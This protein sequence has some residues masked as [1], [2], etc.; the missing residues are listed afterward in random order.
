MAITEKGTSKDAATRRGGDLFIVDNTDGEWK[1]RDYLREWTEISHTFDIAT[2]SFEIGGLL[3]LDGHWQKLDRLRILMG[4]E[5]TKRTKKALLAGLESRKEILDT[6]IEREKEANDFLAGVPGIVEALRGKQIECRI[7]NKDRF[8]AKAYITHSKLSVVPSTALVGSSN[9]SFPGLTENVELNVQI[10]NEVEALQE[11]YER[12]WNEAEDITPEILKLI[13]RHTFAY[14]PFDV[15]AKALQEFFRGHELTATEWEKHQSKIY[16][17][18]AP[19]QRESYHG[20]LKSAESYNGAFLC[21]GV[22]LG[23]TFVGMMLIE[24]LVLHERLNVALFVPKAGREPVWETTLKQYLPHIFGKYSKLEIFNHTD[25]LRGR[26]QEDLES[27]RERADVIIIDEAHHFR[28]TGV[29]GTDETQRKSQYWRMFDLTEGKKL[30]MLTATPINNRITDLQHMIEL[31]THR[32][33]D[34]FK[35]TVLGIH[36]LPGHFRKVE[37]D[38]EKQLQGNESSSQLIETN[39]VEAEKVLSNDTLFQELVQQHSRAYV[40]K[41]LAQTGNGGVVFPN[42]REPKVEP[43]SV[44]QTYGKVLGLIE[45]AFNKEKP[46]FN[47]AIYYPFDYAGSSVEFD[48]F[49]ENRQKQ[50][51][52]L[53]RTS[54][55]KR[56]ESSVEAFKTSC[57]NLLR[58]LLAWVEVHAETAHEKRQLDVWKRQNAELIGYIHDH[59]RELFGDA[60]D[61]IEED[62]VPEEMLEDVERVDRTKFHVSDIID[63][64]ISDLNQIAIFLRELRDFAPSQ[65]KKLTALIKLLKSDPVLKENKVLIFSEFMH[66]ARYLKKQLIEAGISGVEEV[67]SAIKGDRGQIIRRFSPYYNSSSSGKLAAQG[68]PEIRVLVSTD[69][70][71]EGLNLQDATRL[72]NYD[73]HWNPVRLMQRIGR[74]DRRMNP[75]IETLILADHPE[76]KKIRGEIAYWNF[77]PP[78]ELDELLKLYS[79]VAKKTLRIS[80]TLGIEGRKLLKPTDDFEDLREFHKEYEGTESAVERMHLELQELFRKDP[81]LQ[82]RLAKLPGR[83]FSGKEHPTANAKAAFFCYALPGRNPGLASDDDEGGGAE[84]WSTEAGLVQWY[85]YDLTNEKILEDATAMWDLI[86]C[87]PETPR[88]CSLEKK[89]LSEIRKRIEK[90]I[91][92]TYLKKVQAPQGVKATLKAWMELS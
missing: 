53:I 39:L 14:K 20:L 65:D 48:P 50:V 66:T 23:K 12:H 43:Y 85:L 54:F 28:N 74:V 4:N 69:V 84:E 17:I 79:K 3:A 32:K 46:L 27:V 41:S 59:Q 80:K 13:E 9:F 6:S 57:W 7:Y 90:H 78:E 19:Y 40:K 68:L 86:R 36:S 75:D 5:V 2:G 33:A 11:W 87:D 18:L 67:D 88:H 77:L 16:P 8:H 52:G 45:E 31:F 51:V 56:F 29:K 55:L 70:L 76:Q 38:L 81:E 21:D 1:V 42:P 91:K 61:E 35:D 25:L 44:K 62:I 72:I 73:L 71:S 22:G 24:R 89:T 83:V 60:E 34:Y 58:K 37:K 63:D 15:Y 10:R 92:D 49:E 64:T 47:L 30:F 82:A 26:L